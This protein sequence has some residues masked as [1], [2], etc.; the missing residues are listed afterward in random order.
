MNVNDVDL[1]DVM[2]A[3]A[4][5]RG[6]TELP[7]MDAGSETIDGQGAAVAVP[8][9]ARIVAGAMKWFDIAR[10]FGFL[11][12]DDGEGDVLIHYSVL[13]AHER[14][15][16]PEGA[17]VECEVV[18]RPRGRQARS[19]QSFDLSTAIGPDPELVAQ[20][21]RERLQPQALA[22]QA[23]PFEPVTVK[24]FNRLKGYGFVTC[25][26]RQDDIFLHMETAR[27]AQIDDL[28]PG[29]RFEARVAEG[30]KGPLAVILQPLSPDAA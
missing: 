17:R 3:P 14:R 8:E 13:R 4:P 22:D 19:I 12:A 25:A 28:E 27:R 11:S 18:T 29:D 16:L 23:G 2:E 15:S 7:N 9:E 30:P 1:P 21:A 5:A 6:G 24:W 10:G 20:R 26:S